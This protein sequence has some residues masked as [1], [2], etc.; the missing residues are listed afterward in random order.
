MNVDTIAAI[1]TPPG[2][3]GVAI[4]RVSGKKAL[5]IA[6]E[7]TQQKT[8]QPRYATLTPFFDQ[9]NQQI[10]SG[11]VLFFKEPHSFTGEDV[12]EFQGHGGLI[13]MDCLLKRVLLCGARMARPGEFTE[14]AF[15]NNKIDLIQAEAVADMINASTFQAAQSASRSLQGDFSKEINQ[16]LEELIRLRMFIESAID[17][18]DEDIDFISDNH[19]VESIQNV[20]TK[21]QQIRNT[22]QQ[23]ALLQAGI[24][25]V[26]A[27]LPNAGKSSLLNWLSGQETAIVTNVAG[28]TRDVLR[29]RIHIDGLPLTIIDTAGMRDT[30][31][32]IEQE[33]VRRA[34]I[35]IKKAD[36]IL[37]IYDATEGAPTKMAFPE[38]IPII[39]IKNKIDLLVAKND[40]QECDVAVSIVENKNADLLKKAIKN[41]VGFQLTEHSPFMARRRHL[42]ALDKTA[43]CITRGLAVYKKSSSYE[44]LADDL[45]QA[46]QSLGEIT[47]VFSNDDLLGKIFS[48]FCIGK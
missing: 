6:L 48:E 34:Q 32:I 36:L 47:G 42:T 3:G 19:I 41:A 17:F 25:V 27:G 14:R 23:G 22:A 5:S 15:L 29:E 33:G 24:Y 18:T 26:I 20:L 10:D 38:G 21:I 13:I 12:V 2:S 11:L 1:A 40:T 46:S 8:I 16:L 28:T 43:E 35:E 4:V 30:V 9:N 7:I 31:D 39:K 37:W 44:L 45:Y